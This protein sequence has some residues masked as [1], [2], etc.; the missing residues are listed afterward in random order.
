MPWIISAIAG[1]GGGI[2]GALFL[3]VYYQRRA[4]EEVHDF[5]K[6]ME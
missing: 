5:D 3:E 1:F 6:G 4:T 2:F